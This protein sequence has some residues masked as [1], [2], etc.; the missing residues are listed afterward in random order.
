MK[1]CESGEAGAAGTD[2]WWA[3]PG[4][5][6]Q[7]YEGCLRG[8]DGPG[9]SSRHTGHSKPSH[10]SSLHPALQNQSH[11]GTQATTPGSVPE[12]L[13]EH[14][15]HKVLLLIA[16]QAQQLGPQLLAGALG[17]DPSLLVL[18]PL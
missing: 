15:G 7:G 1:V 16:G 17:L 12:D 3:T 6:F 11:T 9:T 18:Q 4:L 5:R 8:T 10:R 13:V 14:V 2:H